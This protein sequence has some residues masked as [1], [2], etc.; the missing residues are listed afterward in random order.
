MFIHVFYD[1]K[2]ELNEEVYVTV[3][4]NIPAVNNRNWMSGKI[5]LWSL[6]LL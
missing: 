6:L 1:Q 2:N 3:L 4:R 5:T